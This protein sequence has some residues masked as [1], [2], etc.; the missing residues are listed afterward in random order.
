MSVIIVI[1]VLVLM[2]AEAGVS[3]SNE[4]ELRARGAVEPVDD[5]YAVMA[6]T[7]PASFVIMAIEGA[8][9]GGPSADVFAAGALVFGLGK[10][11]KYWAIASLGRRWTFRVLVT[12]GMPLVTRGPYAWLRHPNYVG[13]IGEFLGGAMLLN[14]SVTGPLVTLG[15]AY[16]LRRRIVIEDRALGRDH[17]APKGV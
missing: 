4:R 9:R 6:W 8:A 17:T 14:A 1:I 16:L 15:F 3:M 13:V 11:I 5:V 12:P 10:A 7:Y 2:L